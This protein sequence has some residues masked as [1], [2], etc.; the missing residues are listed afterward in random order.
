MDA[1][2]TSDEPLN[3]VDVIWGCS[4]DVDLRVVGVWV[5]SETTLGDN[6]EKLCGIQQ[7]QDGAQYGPLRH[8]KQQ[9]SA[10]RKVTSVKHL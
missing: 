2:D 6:V 4:T 8:T 1:N 9:Y 5:S 7:E 3:R 10:S